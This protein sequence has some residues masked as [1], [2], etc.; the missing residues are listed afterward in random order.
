MPRVST[1]RE[2]SLKRQVLKDYRSNLVNGLGNPERYFPLFRSAGI[3]NKYDCEKIC[4]EVTSKDKV[5]VLMEI[6]DEGRQARD[7]RTPFD[8]LVDVLIQEGVHT[9]V[10]GGL[11]RALARAM[12]R[13]KIG[14]LYENHGKD[15]YTPLNEGNIIAFN[16]QY[17]VL[18]G[19]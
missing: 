18:E 5:G 1:V 12:E 4:H 16:P 3:L 19:S 6:L 7:G 8:V 9:A 15:G 14:V 2:K 13:D 17:G 11:Q 10:A